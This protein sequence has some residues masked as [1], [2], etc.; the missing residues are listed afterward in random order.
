LADLILEILPLFGIPFYTSKEDVSLCEGFSD[1]FYER[2]PS[3]NGFITKDY[4]VLDDVEFALLKSAIKKH[5]DNFIFNQ[6]NYSRNFNFF[7]T[8]SWIIKHEK[9]DFSQKHS[10]ENSL[11]SGVFYLKVPEGDSG[12]LVLNNPNTNSVMP[13]CLKVGVDFWN[14]YNSKT[15]TINPEEGDIFLF[16]SHLAH[17]VTKSNVDEDRYCLAFNVFVSGEFGK[18]IPAYL[19]I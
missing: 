7:I 13:D 14:V 12:S 10:H 17:S 11:I 5:I 19:K 4:F 3:D 15:W 9:G 1:L 2:L 18:N 6:L 8:N 16:P